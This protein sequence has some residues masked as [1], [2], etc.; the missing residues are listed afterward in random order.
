MDA[1]WTMINGGIGHQQINTV[2]TGMNIPS[3]SF[4]SLKSRDLEVGRAFEFVAEESCDKI[5]PNDERKIVEQAQN[6]FSVI[7]QEEEFLDLLDAHDVKAVVI[8]DNWPKVLDEVAHKEIIQ[9]PAYIVECWNGAFKKMKLS[10]GDLDELFSNLTLTLK[11]VIAT[12]KYLNIENTGEL[13]CDPELD[14]VKIVTKCYSVIETSSNSADIDKMTNGET[15]SFWQSDGNARSHWLRLRLKP[16]VVLRRL[17]IAVAANDQSYMP[18][19]VTVAV[20]RNPRSLQEIRD[21]HIPSNVTGFV[22]LLENANV[23]SPFVQI[24]IKRC[25][26]DGCDTRIHGLRTVGYQIMK[27]KGVSVSDASAIWYLS[28]LTSL[29]TVSMES[30][31]VLVQTVLQN[32]R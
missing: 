19:Q 20:G 31:P 26:S 1:H 24:N 29:V 7:S 2:L 5:V 25:L 17:M 14:K 9:E 30:N 22:T 28:L 16:D 21:V 23:S 13:N 18:Q 32:T 10:P 4:P 27:N 8:E 6:D 3:I 11:K 15:V 12:L